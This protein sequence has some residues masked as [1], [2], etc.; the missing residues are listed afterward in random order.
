[1]AGWTESPNQRGTIDILWS[2]SLTLFT[3]LWTVLHLNVPSADDGFW[4]ILLRKIRWGI[5]AFLAPDMLVGFSAMQF[6]SAKISVIQMHS[7]GCVGWTMKHAFYA[8]SGGFVLGSRDLRPFPVTAASIFYL[9]S[10]KH[11]N[12]PA[13]S[14]AEIWDKSKADTFAKG[15]ALIQS[16]W[17]AIQS[18]ARASQGLT[19]SPLELF[20][21]AF[22][23]STIMTYYFWL[24]KPQDVGVPTVLDLTNGTVAEVLS[25]A[26]EIASGPFRDTPLDFI[27]KPLQPWKRRTILQRFGL[28]ERPLRRMPDDAVMPNDMSVLTWILITVPSLMHTA[29]H[30]LGWNHRFPTNIEQ[31]FWRGASVFLATGLPLS[32]ALKALLNACGCRGQPSLVWIWVQ[33]ADTRERG[34]RS[35]IVDVAMTLITFCLILARLYIIIESFISLRKLPADA[36]QVVNWAELI[37]HG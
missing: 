3:A 21:L 12:C 37:P 25:T 35:M 7:I 24:H 1:M 13:I 26:G 18:I 2:C 30:L 34:W 22:V 9:V 20:S 8:N 23:L 19:T 16:I 27:E 36:Y 33:P 4:T 5:F 15:A 10:A 6:H 14:E 31:Q 17:L 28:R 32:T 29:V 11:I